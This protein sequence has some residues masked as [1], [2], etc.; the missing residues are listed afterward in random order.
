MLER[1]LYAEPP[2]PFATALLPAVLLILALALP[3]FAQSVA[4]SLTAAEKMYRQGEYSEAADALERALSQAGDDK[5]K[6]TAHLMLGMVHL[7]RG[8]LDK[9]EEQF[10]LSVV[11]DPSRKL[12]PAR[13][14]P[15]AVKL[16]E[17]AR[18]RNLGSVIVQ[19]SQPEA[20]VHIDN[21]LIGI[22][23][24]EPVELD[25]IPVGRHSIRIVK[26]GYRPLERDIS[27][28][29][30]E[31]SDFYAELE[32]LDETPAVIDH[33][34]VEE[35]KEG[36]SIRVKARVT[37]NKR[38]EEVTLNYRAPGA[39]KYE[40][41]PMEQISRGIYE[42]VIPRDRV[43][44]EGIQYFITAKDFGGSIT[45]D[46]RP[47][48]PFD[49]RVAEL[50]KD[51]PN[52]FHDPITASSDATKL[53]I[54]AK[55]KDN[56]TLA[57][58]GIY[59]KR[60]EDDDYL[61]EEMK[62]TSGR[63]DFESPIPEVFMSS[64]TLNY[65]I[66]AADESGNT[67][68]SGRAD[69]PHVIKI[70][71]VLPFKDG[72]VVERKKEDDGDWT[73]TVTVNVG[74]MKGAEKGQV[75]TVFDASERVVDPE[76]GMV[77]AI[78]QKLTGKIRITA[79]GPASSQ[80][81]IIKEQGRYSVQKGNMIRLRPSPPTGVGGYS[82]KFRENTVT[83]NMSPEP[84]VKGYI[85]YRSESPGGPFEK[86][87]K[88]TDRDDVEHVDDGSYRNKLEDGK[89]YYYRIVAYNDDGVKSDPSKVGY[90]ITKGGPNPPTRLAARSGQ[91]RRIPLKWSASDDEETSGY[92]IFRGETRDGAY[93]EIA[94]IRDRTTAEYVD[95]GGS[96][97]GRELED[98]KVFWYKMISYNKAGKYGNETEP[99]SAATRQKPASPAG[100]G[101][102]SA[103]VRSISLSWD[104]HPDGD[105]E[106][107]R[108]Y[109]SGAPRGP[110]EMIK[111][112]AD[113]SVTEYTDEDKTGA[114]IKDGQKYYYKLTA[115]NV[116]GAESE[117]T[118]PVSG[119]TFGP[120]AGPEDVRA[121]SGLVKQAVVSWTPST[122]P[123]VAGY[124]IYRGKTPDSLEKIKKISDPSASRYKDTGSW[125]ER[126]EDGKV[127]YY[128][129][130]AFNS[131]DVESLD[132]KIVQAL[133]KPVPSAPTG[134]SGTQGEAGRTT[135][136]WKSNPEPDIKS[137]R[138]LRSA[139]PTS[140]FATIASSRAA[141]YEDTGLKNGQTYYYRVQAVD[142]DDLVSEESQTTSVGTKPLPGAPA[143]LEAVAGFDSVTLAW[144]PNPE[145][146]I[147]RYIV[148]SAGFFGKQ[149]IGESGVPSFKV[150]GLKPDSSYTYVVTAVDSD[151][152]MSEPSPPVNVKTLK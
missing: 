49:V 105:V 152:L 30:S 15:N 141:V 5:T 82:D 44:V 151:G 39:G 135:L 53:M 89:K 23:G 98:G 47:D 108:I 7:A 68:Y 56:K 41:A 111:E 80:A 25:E 27:I 125:L 29:P 52:I 40:K 145:P 128:A 54:R 137:Y 102:V 46:G 124:I 74:T 70:F 6:A 126:L 12:S 122:D 134:L 144:E 91:I 48:S 121:T 64:E 136:T 113:R 43:T 10:R 20:E 146:D 13:Y 21:R 4:E 16:H 66:E 42:G 120:P 57:R 19:S 95:K 77:L 61:Q 37:D 69:S 1:R 131:V 142:E 99:V 60:G 75:Y 31:R 150:E 55:V 130:R 139:S 123:E 112:I 93:S 11:L 129:V 85:L 132:P 62:D 22:T 138:I 65:Y 78:N 35:G 81:R 34:P 117:P 72:Y 148:Y 79:P 86:V 110:F 51:A 143:G 92:K 115:V 87:E 28:G 18:A 119:A 109:R 104:M 116:G 88:L 100:F 33:K 90:V 83:W 63:G 84:E 147:E 101:V 17:Q 106:K 32:E 3:A 97:P 73:R 2:G 59:Y 14:P 45:Y 50:D 118:A 71:R 76:T 38:V 103:S 8:F 127:Y 149:K 24:A 94:D 96:E 26:Q 114:T 133:T 107:Y 67:R 36:S 9:A 140:G 58:V